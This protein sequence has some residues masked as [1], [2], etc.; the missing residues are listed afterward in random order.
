MLQ[1]FGAFFVGLLLAGLLGFV[2]GL[3]MAGMPLLWLGVAI[4]VG[5]LAYTLSRPGSGNYKAGLIIGLAVGLLLVGLCFNA[6]RN[7]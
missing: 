2:G 5:G 4:A 3:A 7:I 6:L 1:A